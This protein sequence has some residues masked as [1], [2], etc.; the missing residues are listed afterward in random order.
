MQDVRK[1]EMKRKQIPN[2]TKE[3]LKKTYCKLMIIK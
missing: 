2:E 1:Y 3:K